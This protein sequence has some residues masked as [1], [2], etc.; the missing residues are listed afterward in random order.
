MITTVATEGELN[1]IFDKNLPENTWQK[2]RIYYDSS[3]EELK[4]RIVSNAKRKGTTM[5]QFDE[6]MRKN[7]EELEEVAKKA[8]LKSK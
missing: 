2:V 3:R 5:Q 7:V 6:Q 1:K 8:L 4:A